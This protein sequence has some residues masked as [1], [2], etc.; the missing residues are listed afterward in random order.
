VQY[1]G[2]KLYVK[3]ETIYQRAI[4]LIKQIPHII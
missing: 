1:N 3:N 4:W 2:P